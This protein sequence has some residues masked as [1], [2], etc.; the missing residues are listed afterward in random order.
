MGARG[1]ARA[2]AL[3]AACF[4]PLSPLLAASPGLGGGEE[5]GVS[6]GRIITALIICIIVAVL[7]VLLIRQRSGKVDLAALFARIEMRPRAVQVVETRRLSVHADI[8]L[9]RHDGREYLLLLMAGA[10][11]VL[12]ENDVPTDA[13]PL[14]GAGR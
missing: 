1:A 13:S 11:Q 6:L 7:A 3:A 10:C 5:L 2:T 8:C 14:T 9:L 4:S 12:R